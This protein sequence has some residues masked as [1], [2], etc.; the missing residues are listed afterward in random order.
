MADS[1][2]DVV[3]LQR[4]GIFALG[5]EPSIRTLRAWTKLRRIPHYRLG[6]FVFF[7]PT[8]VAA[9]IRAKLRVPAR[10][11]DTKKLTTDLASRP[12]GAK[13]D[14]SPAKP[15]PSAQ[16][17]PARIRFRKSDAGF[18]ISNFTN[19]SGAVVHRVSG[20]LGDTRIRR[21]FRTRQE[22]ESEVQ[23][24]TA[25]AAQV[26]SQLRT[27]VTHL[28]PT[29]L[30]EAETAHELIKDRPQSLLFYIDHALQRFREPHEC[31]KLSDAVNDYLAARQLEHEQKVISTPYLQNL[32]RGLQELAKHFS[33]LAVADLTGP[34]VMAYLECRQPSIKT[35]NNRRGVISAFLKF[36]VQHG[37]TENDPLARIPARRWRRPRG[38]AKTFS[39][40]QTREF[41]HALEMFADGRFVPYFALAFFAGIRP[42]VPHGEMSRIT[43]ASVKLDEGV[44]EISAEISKVREPRNLV[45]QPNL[46]AWLR[47]YP[48]KRFAIVPN[49]FQPRRAQLAQ[50]FGLSHDV[51]RHT[52]ISMFVAKFRSVGE[53][54]LQSG[55]SESIIRRHY[56][57]LKTSADA[58]AYFDI[59]PQRA[60]FSGRAP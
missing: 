49:D 32:K 15:D 47:A 22:A 37:W 48:L 43:P 46:A 2:T 1:L 30:S 10:G 25:R 16:P 52:F 45:I 6:H 44:I 8:E 57:K 27:A 40:A 58:D 35:F 24:L 18:R 59:R 36:C 33:E 3:G 51:T 41:M 20:W 9:H 5:H 14:R 23:V 38:A 12:S 28:T 42:G 17:L 39:A 7:D 55:N 29:Q 50:R 60:E 56:L 19:P 11:E 54:A 31:K 26:D 4:S 53:A 13:P 21:N 34:R